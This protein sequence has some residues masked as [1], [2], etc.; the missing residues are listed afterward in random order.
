MTTV[1]TGPEVRSDTATTTPARRISV[2]GTVLALLAALLVGGMTGWFVRANIADSRDVV[3]VG[4]AEL[5]DRQA[6]IAE[7]VREYEQAWQASD[8]QA[9]ASMFT[10]GGTATFLGT[11]FRVDDDEFAAYVE[12][13][14]Y[15]SLDVSTPILV[16]G[17]RALMFHEWSGPTYADVMQFTDEGELLLV[18]HEIIN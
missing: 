8:A 11:T 6:Q 5:T 1:Q 3:A 16:N 2:V 13:G 18:S 9:V 17:D 4:Q 10:D 7:F 14:N 15:T 12:D